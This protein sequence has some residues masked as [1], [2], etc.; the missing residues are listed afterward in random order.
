M[1]FDREKFLKKVEDKLSKE[2][3]SPDQLIIQTI[4]ALDELNKIFNLCF[5][6]L[7]EWYAVHFP[8]FKAKEPH[9]YLLVA[10]FFNRKNPDQKKLQQLFGEQ[11]STILNLSKNSIGSILEEEDILAIEEYAKFGLEVENKKIYLENYLKQL[12]KKVAPNLSYLCGELLAARLI[13]KAGGIKKLALLPSSTI[14]VLGAE[15]ALFKHLK[16]GSPPPK[17]GIIFQHPVISSTNKKNRGK[18]AR[19]LASKIA[20]AAKADAFSK[21]FIAPELKEKFDKRIKKI[22]SK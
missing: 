14:Q 10:S 1:G 4:N 17:H 8:E 21:K 19:S 5:E 2:L 15:K 13:E 16:S 11:A 12:T 6:R 18:I 3:S 9:K 7:S 20:I 22:L